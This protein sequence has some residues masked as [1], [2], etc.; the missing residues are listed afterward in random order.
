[1]RFRK[2]IVYAYSLETYRYEYMDEV[3]F[4]KDFDPSQ[5]RS[6]LVNHDNYPNDIKVYEV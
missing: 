6:S 5:V 4:T 3:Y 1:M 2:F